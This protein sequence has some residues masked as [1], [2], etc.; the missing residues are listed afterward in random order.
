MNCINNPLQG[1][2]CIYCNA[3]G[4]LDKFSELEVLVQQCHPS[5]IGITETKL[6]DAID[7]SELY[8]RGY[9][10]FRVDRS[11]GHHGGGVTLYV[12]ETLQPVSYT[13]ANSFPEQVWCHATFNKGERLYIGVCYR[14]PNSAIYTFDTDAAVLQLIEEFRDKQIMLMG[15]FNYPEINWCNPGLS[16]SSSSAAGRFQECV[17]DNFLTQHVTIPT[18]KDAIL[19]LVLTSDPDLISTIDIQGVLGNSDHSTLT[20]MLNQRSPLRQQATPR[21]DYSK[22]DF[23]SVKD[24]L[25]VI[26]WESAFYSMSVNE[27]WKFFRDGLLALLHAASP[28]TRVAADRRKPLWMN[29]RAFRA[30][31]KKYAVFSKYKSNQHPACKKAA[32]NARREIRA[33]KLMFETKLAAN[34]K[35]DKKSFY[36]YVN[37]KRRAKPSLGPLLS[38]SGNGQLLSSPQELAEEFNRYFTS[39]FTQEDQRIPV[40]EDSIRNIHC[41]KLSDI[42]ISTSSIH[43]IISTLPLDK[44]PGVDNISSRILR[45]LADSVSTPLAMLFRKSL[46]NGQVP[47][48]WR[49][50]NVTPIFKKGDHSQPGN[51]RPI[52]LTS[53][54]CKIMETL[55]RDSI[56]YHLESSQLIRQSQHGFR[57]GKSCLTN[58]LTFLDSV[59]RFVDA[60][61]PV[62]VIY[63]DFAKA[64]DRVPHRRLLLKLAQHGLS[65]KLLDWIS[66]WLKDRVQR[67]CIK[68]VF[69]EWSSV[70]SGVPQGSVL[71][72]L[73]FLVFINDLDSHVVNAILKFADD[74]KIWSPAND[75]LQFQ[76]LQFDL[77]A[78]GCWSDTWQMQ[79]NVDKCHVLHVGSN[80]HQFGYSMM[81]KPLQSV[82]YERDLGLIVSSD[83]KSYRHCVHAYKRASGVLAMIQRTVQTRDCQILTALYKTLV[84]P[85]LEYCSPCW[86]PHYAKDKALLERVQHR[87][88]R[89]FGDLR[90]LD[91]QTRLR[92]LNLW[93][94]EERRHRGDLIEVYKIMHQQSR[95]SPDMFFQFP[96]DSITRGH[97]Q[98]L[99]KQHCHRDIRL[100]FFSERVVSHWNSLSQEVVSAKSLNSFKGHLE[101]LRHSEQMGLF[102][103]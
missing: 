50:A 34:I 76:Q 8:L 45:Q 31:K 13:P 101:R 90:H 7:D 62:D 82:A 61:D 28:V 63:L 49:S 9:K 37:S 53:Q 6:S 24:G 55:L 47:D 20:W 4:L 70:L 26:D 68:G 102:M 48:D 43:Q 96:V 35:S 71:G 69:S 74:T 65:G 98:K 100:H 17:E 77:D 78:L 36:A 95:I 59:T 10:M 75:D 40:Q 88:T 94:L 86:S 16:L 79:F 38:G 72:P 21:I 85:L 5:V 91:Y 64:F 32:S 89:L 15:D 3:N 46:D 66:A 80:N 103:D 22:A 23:Q 18:R 84:R 67:T 14:T 60:G 1:S 97:T 57:H 2:R 30:V 99:L 41:P 44:S 33:A 73:L 29:F 54:C 25:A 51:Y 93:S 39:V 19:D 52:S 11:S 27:A 58:L 92:H 83:L 12:E 81:G 56:T 42:V 87:F